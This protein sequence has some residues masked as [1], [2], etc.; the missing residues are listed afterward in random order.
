MYVTLYKI[1]QPT[2][3]MYTQTR[4]NFVCTNLAFPFSICV[5]LGACVT[6][7]NKPWKSLVCVYITFGT[8][9]I[10][11]FFSAEI[12]KTVGLLLVRHIIQ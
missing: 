12:G 2:V 4:A 1:R 7:V 8:L 9:L 6:S 10:M 5:Y 11:G 3:Y